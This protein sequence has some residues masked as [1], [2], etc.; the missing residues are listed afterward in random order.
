MKS[1]ITGLMTL[2]NAG[3]TFYDD[4]SGRLYFGPQEEM[5]LSDGPY[6]IFFVVSD[7]NEDTFKD[8]IRNIYL[9]FSLFSG[10]SSAAEILDMDAHLTTAFNDQLFTVSA[11]TVVMMH[12]LQGNG[13][14]NTP[15]D[16]EAGTGRYWQYDIDFEL[17]VQT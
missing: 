10:A 1:I 7:T 12:R 4:V 9:Q 3:G 16:V 11:E 15:A 8:K 13:P 2:F 14:I 17:I 5:S 6:A